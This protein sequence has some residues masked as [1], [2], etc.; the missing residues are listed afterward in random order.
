M[1]DSTGGPE[2]CGQALITE[3]TCLSPGFY[4]LTLLAA[5][6]A[7]PAQPG[8]F[9]QIRPSGRT[10]LDPLLA[11]PISLFSINREAGSISLIYKVVGRGTALLAEYCQG[12]L[13]EIMGPF[14]NGFAVPALVNNIAFV[15]GGVGMPPLFCLAEQLTKQGDG[16]R[17]TF[18]YGGRKQRELLELDS[19]S[20]LGVKVRLATDDG[21]QGR[22]AAGP[23]QHFMQYGSI[24][25]LQQIYAHLRACRVSC[26]CKPDCRRAGACGNAQRHH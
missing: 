3:N 13:V 12:Q 22:P 25:D 2:F 24:D 16:P 14:G 9:I 19:W 26:D 11:R 8:Q 7:A 10:S 1:T 17:I 5:E 21:S 6:V 20:R 4:R 15:A 18:F 23:L